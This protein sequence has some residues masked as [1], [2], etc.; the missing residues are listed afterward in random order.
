MLPPP[1]QTDA[2]SHHLSCTPITPPVRPTLDAKFNHC[3]VMQF[4]HNKTSFALDSPIQY[5][6]AAL[7]GIERTLFNNAFTTDPSSE[8]DYS[9]T[10]V[11]GP[12]QSRYH[13]A[14]RALC[15]LDL[16]TKT[17]ATESGF[18]HPSPHY[19][20]DEAY[21]NITQQHIFILD[22]SNAPLHP[23]ANDTVV[24]ILYKRTS[25]QWVTSLVLIYSNPIQQEAILTRS[26]R[27]TR[28]INA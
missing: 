15:P 6:P 28:H 20:E 1:T 12:S 21:Y 3:P 8:Y 10:E 19:T 26:H 17:T 22:P 24:Q 11:P 9:L 13:S 5:A 7:R 25:E 23:V 2:L 4:D 27:D 16:W 14:N 18:S